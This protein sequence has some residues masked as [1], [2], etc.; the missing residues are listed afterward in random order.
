MKYEWLRE[1][2]IHD[3]GVRP[4]MNGHAFIAVAELGVRNER[5]DLRAC[6]KIYRRDYLIAFDATP[7]DEL[8]AASAAFVELAR[9]AQA[10]LRSLEGDDFGE[11]AKYRFVP[12][13]P[14]AWPAPKETLWQ[15]IRS[16]VGI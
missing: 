11:P 8:R 9:H 15:R 16:R 3:C 2:K 10:D 12:P 6:G 5:G 1:P 4:G 13:A 14:P 7:A